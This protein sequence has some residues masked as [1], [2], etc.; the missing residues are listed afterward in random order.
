MMETRPGHLYQVNKIYV[1][2]S[3][4]DILDYVISE[5]LENRIGDF[6]DNQSPDSNLTFENV[7]FNYRNILCN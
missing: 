4:N 7:L 3:Q 5:E 2:V 6:L 1:E